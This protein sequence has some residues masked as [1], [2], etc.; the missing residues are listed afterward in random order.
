MYSMLEHED[1]GVSYEGVG[2]RWLLVRG[3][4]D[5]EAQQSQLNSGAKWDMIT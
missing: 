4:A 2:K 1:D 5:A 3:E